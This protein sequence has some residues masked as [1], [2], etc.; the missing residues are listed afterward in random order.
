MY[1]SRMLADYIEE[2]CDTFND[3]M[4]VTDRNGICVLV[5]RR[6]S[7][8]TGIPKRDIVGHRVQ[9]MVLH[10][11][12]DTQLNSKVVE[13]GQDVKSVQNVFNG[14]R[15]LLDGHPVLDKKGK[16]AYVVT[17]I[18]DV[19]ALTDLRREIAAQKELLET[20][21]SLNNANSGS[22]RY[23]MVMQSRAMQRLCA[24]AEAIA[25]TDAT[26]LL[27]GET[28]VGKDVVARRIHHESRRSSAPFIKVDCGSIPENLIE[29]EFFGYAPGSFSGASRHGKAGL[30]EAANT[31]TVFL[32]EIGELPMPMQS[33]LLRVLQDFEVMRVGATE[34]RKVDVRIIAATNKDLGREV[35]RGTFRPDLYY[36]LKVAVLNIPPLRERRGDIQPLAE[37]FLAYYC[38]RYHKKLSFSDEAMDVM[39]HYSW[40][41]NVRELENLVQGIVAT[42]KRGPV[43]PEDLRGITAENGD[44]E[45]NLSFSL[46]TLSGHSLKDIMKSFEESVLDRGLRQFGSISEM[47]RQFQMDRS[48]IFRKVRD[49]HARR[50]RTA[51]TRQ[52][53]NRQSR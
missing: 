43:K 26:V 38:A 13:T 24:E 48:T 4:C 40:P 9:D 7:E 50:K 30:L 35:A 47:A 29:T 21:Q 23:P 6:H 20:F 12:F 17:V 34:P 10:G 45:D 37:A 3:A 15:L 2:L 31:G 32:D 33:R 28:G 42:A 18:R 27:Q 41:G 51:K 46:P 52:G 16:V 39:C 14:R 49:M 19:T 8:L 5:N 1:T 53:T 44:G 11:V 22:A 25:D 36:R